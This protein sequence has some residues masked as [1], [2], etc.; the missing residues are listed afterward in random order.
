MRT[1]RA[2]LLRAFDVFAK[3]PRD[4]DLS[5]ELESHLQLHI[6]DNLRAGMTY[7]EARRTALLRLGGVEMLKE[8]Y[9]DRR[10]LPAIEN[11]LWHLS[12]GV[13]GFRRSPGF[14]LLAIAI[15]ALS[16][17]ASTALFSIID[18]LLLRPLP[19][20]KP[21]SLVMLWESGERHY[22]SEPDQVAPTNF[23]DWQ[24]NSHS[25]AG[26]G[27]AHPIGQNLTGAGEAVQLQV[28]NVTAGVLPTLGIP[29]QLGRFIRPEED[30]P[31]RARVALISFELWQER[32][33]GD[34]HILG[35]TLTLDGQPYTIIGVMPRGFRFLNK[36]VSCWTPIGLD[37]KARW[38]EGRYLRVVAR[39]KPGIS[40]ASAQAELQLLTQRMAKEAPQMEKG[41]SALIQPLR[42][43]YVAKGRLPL[44]ALAG[45][46]GC[47]LLIACTNI[48]GLL[49]ARG[50]ARARDT[51]IRISLG[52]T[53]W[54]VASLHLTEA[55]LLTFAGGALG[56]LLAWTGT[57][58]LVR[59]LPDTL[60]I[61]SLG[62]VHFDA[63]VFLFAAL[64][65]V[66]A[67]LLCAIAPA[68]AAGR[69]DPQTI[70]RGGSS[71]H[72]RSARLRY[73]FV[74]VQT[75][76]ALALLSGAGLLLR[77]L[78]NLYASPLGFEADNV[79]TFG[80]SLPEAKYRTDSDQ[81]VFFER[82]L[83]RLQSLPGVTS[84]SMVE[85][86][87]L[88]GL[89]V[90]TY[91]Y[92]GGQP[93]LPPGEQ[94]IAQLRAIAPR[95]FATLGIPLRAGRDFTQ[96]DS[97]GA[98]R[99]YIINEMLARQYFP[100]ED[101]IGHQ[102]SILWN[103][104]EPGVIVGV[105]GDVRYTGINND[106]LPTVYWPEW[107]HIF[108]DMNVLLKTSVPPLSV[109]SAAAHAIRRLDPELPINNV[110]PLTALR[111]RETAT[112]RLLS[113]LLAGLAALALVLACSGLFGLL[114]YLVTQRTR[115]IG[116]RMAL[117]A[118]PK[119]ILLNVL[120]EGGGLVCAGLL[121]GAALSLAAGRFLRNLLYG[122]TASDFATLSSVVLI[123]LVIAFL[124]VIAPASRASRVDPSLALREE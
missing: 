13:R 47:I 78:L 123:L 108:S 122:V 109:T 29:P 80:L 113:A 97:A 70:L 59:A 21:E 118:L 124:A 9:R 96:R 49:L 46:L 3:A 27:A 6:D 73:V 98:P 11:V 34:T 15:F 82:A 101:P 19:F 121:L 35:R 65:V 16:I 69:E 84:A 85:D 12:S 120:L 68:L 114:G 76:L 26:M 10:S 54:R 58:A 81:R 110:A 30:W 67:G 2:T 102:I 56:F 107:Q 28:L 33:A 60:D 112:N 1:L 104:R 40:P 52:A 66:G 22:H 32:F 88:G 7:D 44:L 75:A 89:G 106:V 25:F 99:S 95:Y 116:I 8:T 57:P 38:N 45:A 5:A 91:F 105:V 71:S 61:T 64:L 111:E 55:F 77:S 43:Q 86:L 119:Q 63:R 48:G 53:R 115:E 50:A 93:D 20:P 74:V 31:Q 4:R 79:L 37:P 90:G 100:H 103:G 17:G 39:L 41:W 18:A 72:A 87:P 92:I 94:P 42:E 117:G 14:A 24:Q 23:F 62:P 36:L 83:D 51:A